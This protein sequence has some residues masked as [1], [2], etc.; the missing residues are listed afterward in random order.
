MNCSSYNPS[1]W[2]GTLSIDLPCPDTVEES[3]THANILVDLLPSL[4]SLRLKKGGGGEEG[5]LEKQSQG[6]VLVDLLSQ[7]A[8]LP[9]TQLWPLE[10]TGAEEGSHYTV[11]DAT[12]RA[13]CASR[14]GL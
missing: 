8:K 10:L 13:A 7:K 1:G 11:A 9:A 12:E 3:I 5:M 6:P 2:A 4:F 14:T